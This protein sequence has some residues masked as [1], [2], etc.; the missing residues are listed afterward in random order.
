MRTATVRGVELLDSMGQLVDGV[1]LVAPGGLHAFDAAVELRATGR[2]DVEVDVALLAGEFEV[3]LELGA[4]VDLDGLD[5]EGGA[6]DELVEEA[7]GGSGGGVGSGH[8]GG[9]AGVAIQGSE[10][11][12]GLA[13]QQ[14]EREGVDRDGLAGGGGQQRAA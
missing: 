10:V 9:P 12:D 14:A 1:E 11:L 6:A 4:A 13:G 2:Q 3:F 8:G 5:G 7:S